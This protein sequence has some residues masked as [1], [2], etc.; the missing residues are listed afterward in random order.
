[1]LIKAHRFCSGKEIYRP[2]SHVLKTIT[3]EEKTHRVRDIKPGEVVESIWDQ[4][5]NPQAEFMFTS[6]NNEL[7]PVAHH[8]LLYNESDA[9]EDAVLFPEGSQKAENAMIPHQSTQAMHAFEHEGPSI[10]K[11]IFDL[12]TDDEVDGE[13]D[14]ALGHDGGKEHLDSTDESSTEPPDNGHDRMKASPDA[15]ILEFIT[16]AGADNLPAAMERMQAFLT[17]NT[18]RKPGERFNDGFEL[19]MDRERAFGKYNFRSPNRT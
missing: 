7:Q 11:Y 12:D 18:G 8:H 1:M 4:I 2:A 10:V 3:R 17:S 13:A 19:F 6:T 15:Q 9:L 14:N 16:R 5:T